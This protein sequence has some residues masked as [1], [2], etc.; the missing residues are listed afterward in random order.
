VGIG[1]GV[2]T[3]ASESNDPKCLGIWNMYARI[4]GNFSQNQKKILYIIYPYN[5]GK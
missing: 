4:I 1:W 3:W 5:Y 2:A